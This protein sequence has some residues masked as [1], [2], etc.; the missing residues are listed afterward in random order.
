MRIA[1][2]DDHRIWAFADLI[3]SSYCYIGHM[4]R[5]R[6]EGQSMTDLELKASRIVLDTIIEHHYVSISS[7][8][9][10]SAHL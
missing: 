2:N 8:F 4:E 7:I 9:A 6:V 1:G 5:L 3:I 10:A